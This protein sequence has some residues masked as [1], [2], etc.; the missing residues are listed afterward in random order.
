MT[1]NKRISVNYKR[2]TDNAY[3]GIITQELWNSHDKYIKES[4]GKD[5]WV[6]NWTF[7]ETLENSKEETNGKPGNDEYS[8]HN[9]FKSL[10]MIKSILD[11]MEE[12]SVNL[13]MNQ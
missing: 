2:T 6:K 3:V 9:F 13:K 8:I 4:I 11:T 5:R 12:I 10:N 1:H 7:Q